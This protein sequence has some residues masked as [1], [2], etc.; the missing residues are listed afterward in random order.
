MIIKKKKEKMKRMVLD[1]KRMKTK[2]QPN[3][4]K[5]E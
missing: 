1:M 2:D 5:N 4:R 3:E